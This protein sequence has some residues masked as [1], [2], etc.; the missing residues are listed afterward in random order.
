MGKLSKVPERDLLK[1]RQWAGYRAN[2]HSS[3]ARCQLACWT[4]QCQAFGVPE[5]WMVMRK[6]LLPE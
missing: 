2:D 4:L 3:V 5:K 1:V 6:P